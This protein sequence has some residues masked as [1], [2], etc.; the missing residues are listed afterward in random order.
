MIHSGRSI[1]DIANVLGH[2]PS[3][4]LVIYGHAFDT[5]DIDQRRPLFEQVLEARSDTPR[6][7]GMTKEGV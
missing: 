5:F 2:S 3:M 4:T 6:D 1:P 7:H